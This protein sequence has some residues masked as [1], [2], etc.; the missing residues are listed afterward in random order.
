MDT[1]I[2]EV[3][4]REFLWNRKHS[5]YK[6]RSRVDE[7]WARVAEKVGISSKLNHIFS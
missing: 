1:L 4:K 2:S 6:D 7:E 5:G 3:Q